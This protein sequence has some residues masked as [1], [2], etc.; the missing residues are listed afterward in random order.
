[1]SGFN[2]RADAVID[3][4]NWLIVRDM[5]TAVNSGRVDRFRDAGRRLDKEVELDNKAGSYLA[6]LLWKRV[7]YILGRDP[8]A[9]D[10][11][12]I[13]ARSNAQLCEMFN[14]EIEDLEEA[15]QIS[16]RAGSGPWIGDPPRITGNELIVIVAAILGTLF[17]D[18]PAELDAMFPDLRDWYKS[19]F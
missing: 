13:A 15:M 9:N 19:T 6:F 16:F 12:A 1:M 17:D 2:S 10:L 5:I 4:A 8:S 7:T 18:L 3:R 14:L 11:H